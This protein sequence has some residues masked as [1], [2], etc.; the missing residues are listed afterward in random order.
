[1]CEATAADLVRAGH[2]CRPAMNSPGGDSYHDIQDDEDE[3]P[4]YIHATSNARSAEVQTDADTAVC[5]SCQRLKEEVRKLRF[6]FEELGRESS[7]HVEEQDRNV[8]KHM[9]EAKVQFYTGLPKAVF[10][11]ILSSI[12]PVLPTA[13]K[14]FPHHL[15]LLTFLIKLRLNVP[16]RDLAYRFIL[17]PRTVSQSFRT[18]LDSMF[19]LCKGLIKFPSREVCESWLT[20]KELKHFPRLR[21]I[22]D[23]T[24]VHVA[25][26]LNLDEQQVVWSTY[27]Q[28][29][30]LKYLV[31]VNPHGAV[32]FEVI[33]RE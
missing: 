21:A 11:A 13:R 18:V 1:M 19:H 25:R 30:T 8:V 28:N 23:C 33:R 12:V 7:R 26:P 29:T 3:V 20:E 14:K 6:T 17:D 9:S 4:S 16:F 5:N 24:E 22:I 32:M 31:A 10:F 15:Q 2:H 27:K